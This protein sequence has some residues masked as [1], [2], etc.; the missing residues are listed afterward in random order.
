M[1]EL[2][3]REAMREKKRAKYNINNNANNK[4]KKVDGVRAAALY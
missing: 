3:E 4:D 1:K 2:E